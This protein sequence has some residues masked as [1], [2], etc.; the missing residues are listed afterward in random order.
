MKIIFSCTNRLTRYLQAD[1]PRLPTPA[2]EQAGVRR[3]Q[4]T[5]EHLTFQC[6]LF[7]AQQPNRSA[8]TYLIALEASSRYCLILP[9]PIRLDQ[10]DIAEQIQA[11][12]LTHTGFQLCEAQMLDHDDLLA[13]EQ[14]YIAMQPEISWVHNTDLSLQGTITQIEFWLQ[15]ALAQAGKRGL[16]DQQ[17]FVLSLQ[18]NDCSTRCTVDGKKQRFI[19]SQRFVAESMLRFGPLF[20]R[21]R[22]SDNVVD[23]AAYKALKG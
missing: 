10:T 23:F 16:N 14:L 4:S 9:L 20:L 17:V 8:C 19:P 3:L 18:A 1:L 15:D 11:L 7:E 22:Q 5:R 6:H 2:G 21:Q 12:Y 13:L